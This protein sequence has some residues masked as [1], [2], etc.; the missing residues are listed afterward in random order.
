MHY[1]KL[2]GK[3]RYV[4]EVDIKNFFD[5]IDHDWL[6]KMVEK[7]VQDQSILKLIR[8]WLKAGIKYDDGHVEN[9]EKGTPQGGVISPI[10]ANIYLHYVLDMWYETEVRLHCWKNTTL[11]R[12]ADD[13]V[14]AFQFEE[15]A[16]WFYAALPVRFA[17]FG[18]ILSEEKT[19]KI[20]FSRLEKEKSKPFDFLG[21]TFRWGATRKGY[22][23]VLTRTSPNKFHKV[24]REFAEWIRE[25]RHKPLR[26]IMEQVKTKLRGHRN[27][28]GRQGNSACVWKVYRAVEKLLFKWL[29]RRSQRK[30]Y[31]WKTFNKMLDF[32]NV[33]SSARIGNNGVQISF[34]SLLLD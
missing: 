13:F 10:L 11:V 21:F 16:R 12:Y 18:L 17:K 9:P 7:R 2:T 5:S 20:R 31:S 25:N 26:C 6:I 32:Y 19:N 28:F 14:A 24:I 33:K 27:Y 1:G 8:K 23:I 34:L 3:P 22:D 29:N 4:V 30:S 15:D